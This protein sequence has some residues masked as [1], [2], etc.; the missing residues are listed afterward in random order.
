MSNYPKSL[1]LLLCVISGHLIFNAATLSAQNR[2]SSASTKI[3]VIETPELSKLVMERLAL[4]R[5]AKEAG[6]NPPDATFILVDVRSDR[7]RSVSVIPGAISQ[8]QFEKEIEKYR[9]RVVI[10]YCTVGGRC[11]DFSRKLAQ[12]GW[13]VKSYRGS[14]IDWVQNQ[15]PLVNPKGE[16]TFQ[17]H[18]NGGRFQ[19]PSNYQPVGN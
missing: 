6:V 13:T 12:A 8:P 7:E 14:I 11:G 10:P 5:R 9:G 1:I 19:L 3:G 17:L 15:Q 2:G 18:T 16:Q 4:E